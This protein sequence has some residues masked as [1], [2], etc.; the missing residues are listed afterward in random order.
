MEPLLSVLRIIRRCY[1]YMP[2]RREEICSQCSHAAE[3]PHEPLGSVHI[4]FR[5]HY[6]Q[7]T[8]YMYVLAWIEM[9]SKTKFAVPRGKPKSGRIWREPGEKYVLIFNATCADLIEVTTS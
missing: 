2:A 9:S 8:W 3:N 6:Q 1:P 4:L 7:P 5:A